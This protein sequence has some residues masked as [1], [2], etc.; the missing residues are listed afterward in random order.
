M[1]SILKPTKGTMTAII[2]SIKDVEASFDAAAGATLA[3]EF[4]M[5]L[6]AEHSEEVRN[7]LS[8]IVKT[9]K[10]YTHERHYWNC[11]LV[12][13]DQAIDA[14]FASGLTPEEQ[15]ALVEFRDLRN[16]LFHAD[17][18]NLMKLLKITPSGRELKQINGKL[19]RMELKEHQIRDAAVAI[20][21]NGGF[22][23]MRKLAEEVKGILGKIIMGL[24]T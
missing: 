16:K 17:F 1:S 9:K 20:D 5:R 19:E 12:D 13:L 11:R 24:D 3:V 21:I 10:R 18:V 8:L 7:E 14:V 4:R 22:N 23:Q 2:K 15:K 6:L